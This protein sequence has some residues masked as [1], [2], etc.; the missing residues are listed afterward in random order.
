MKIDAA[1][2]YMTGGV[3]REIVPNEKVVFSSGAVG[4][5]PALD[6]ERLDDGPLVTVQLTPV[7]RQTEMVVH[8]QLPDHLSDEPPV[9][10]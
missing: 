8:L 7:G 10:G 5:W 6:L 1:T 3:Y 4:G 2:Q 9:N